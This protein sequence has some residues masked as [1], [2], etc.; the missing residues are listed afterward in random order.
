[1]VS[2]TFSL[3]AFVLLTCAPLSAQTRS[4]MSST[5]VVVISGFRSDASAEQ[6][7]RTS[8]RGHGTSGMY[9]LT[10]DLEKAGYRTLFF[11]WNGST[12][13]QF[14]EKA[15]PGAKAIVTA[16]TLDPHAHQAVEWDQRIHTALLNRIKE[17]V[18]RQSTSE[19]RATES[20]ATETVNAGR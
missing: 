10:C 9:Q 4:D 20:P 8:P 17:T 18:A 12:A 13:G 19:G 16:I 5:L 7:S 6:I 1:M 3:L 2:K 11:N 15:A 14:T